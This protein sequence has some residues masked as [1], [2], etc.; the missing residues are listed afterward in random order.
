MSSCRHGHHESSWHVL[1]CALLALPADTP[2]QKNSTALVQRLLEANGIVMGKTR[3]HE[4]VR[5]FTSVELFG[6]AMVAMYADRWHATFD[7]QAYGVTSVS[8][9]FGPVLNPYN[10]TRIPGGEQMLLLQPLNTHAHLCLVFENPMH[11]RLSAGSTGGGG[12]ALATRSV[13]G[14]F[15]TGPV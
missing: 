4:L 8:P 7:V 5:P 2:A 6:H 9:V 1:D 14:S 15:C 11:V 12:V 13:A 3:C 10:V